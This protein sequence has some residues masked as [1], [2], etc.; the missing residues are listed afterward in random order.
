VWPPGSNPAL[1]GLEGDNEAT[2]ISVEE[3]RRWVSGATGWTRTRVLGRLAGGGGGVGVLTCW[4]SLVR[5]D[6]TVGRENSRPGQQR[7][8]EVGGD[9]DWCMRGEPG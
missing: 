7:A 2:C 8:A 1:R 9:S 6:E 3:V 5:I 4:P